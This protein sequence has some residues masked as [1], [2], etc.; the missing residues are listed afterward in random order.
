MKSKNSTR[1]LVRIGH[2]FLLFFAVF[3]LPWWSAGILII[4]GFSYSNYYEGMVAGMLLDYLYE[5]PG[6]TSHLFLLLS[7]AIFVCFLFIRRSIT[8]RFNV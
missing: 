8:M 5:M 6:L 3:F 7:L 1:S 4:L 2:F